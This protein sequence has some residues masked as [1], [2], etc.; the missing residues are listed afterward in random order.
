MA[1]DR[2]LDPR[3]NR[4]VAVVPPRLLQFYSARYRRSHDGAGVFRVVETREISY[5]LQEGNP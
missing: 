1:D 4:I 2:R 5:P 3:G